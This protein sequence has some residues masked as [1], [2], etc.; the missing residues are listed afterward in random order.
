MTQYDYVIVGAGSSG[1]VLARQLSDDPRNRVLLVEA[2]GDNQN[3][4]IKMAGGFM[5]ILGRPD[6]FWSFPVEPLPGRRKEVHTYGKGLGGSSAVNGTWYLRG[7]PRDYDQ[8]RDQGLAGWGWDELER[9]YRWLENYRAPGADPSRGHDGPL[10]ITQSDHDSTVYRALIKACTGMGVPWLD[11]ICTP[12]TQGVGRTQYTVDRKGKRSSSYESFLAP[13]RNRPNLTIVTDCLVRRVLI[14]GRR[15]TGIVCDRDGTEIEYQAARD[16]IVSSGVYRSPQLLQLSGIGAGSLLGSLGIAVV[17]DLPAVGRNLCD[18]QKFG[19]SYDLHNHPGT[20]REFLGWRLYRNALRYFLT[21]TGPLA[22]VGM[23]LTMLRSSEGEP[24]WPDFQLAAAPFAMRTVKEMAAAP[25]S[26]ISTKPGITFSGYHLRPRSRGSVAITSADAS[27]SPR[28]ESGMWSDSYDI[29]KALELLKMLRSMA[30][31]P[32]MSP[33]VGK[34]RMPGDEV[35]SDEALIEELRQMVDP[36]LHGT[37]TCSMGTNPAT[38]VVD[39]RCRVHGIDGLRVVDCS[40]M[41]TPVSGNTNGP[42]MAVGAR[43]AELILEDN[44]G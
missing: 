11:D 38:S 35:R 40:I 8:W 31:S 43:A 20:N 5:K 34:E 6:Y 2:G 29:G 14:N 9:C 21:G 26:P 13:I 28:V 39:A 3:P 30:A 15:A 19:I 17:Q 7:Q 12:A 16:V 23:P 37:G 4:F 32:A 10:Q 1:C 25:G 27:A 24:D 44:A 42:A 33:F 36:G 41:P 22:R 18:H